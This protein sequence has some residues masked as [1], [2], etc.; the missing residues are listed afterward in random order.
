MCKP[1]MLV[2]LLA[3]KPL[4]VWATQ[5]ISEQEHDFSARFQVSACVQDVDLQRMVDEATCVALAQAGDMQ[6]Q[7]HLGDLLIQN[8]STFE[9]GMAWLKKAAHANFEPAQMRLGVVYYGDPSQSEQAIYWL[10]KAAAHQNLYA[11][12]FLA[13]IYKAGIG[14]PSSYAKAR[15]WYLQAANQHDDE[16][17]FYYLGL[18]AMTDTKHYNVDRAAYWFE[19]ASAKGHQASKKQLAL[20]YIAHARLGTFE[21]AELLLR[22]GNSG[23]QI[24]Q[25]LIDWIDSLSAMPSMKVGTKIASRWQGML[26]GKLK[27][28]RR[29]GAWMLGLESPNAWTPEQMDAWLLQAQDQDPAGQ[30]I[31]LGL[32]FLHG[33]GFGGQPRLASSYFFDA[34]AQH[35]TQAMY[36]LANIYLKGFG[37]Q[38]DPKLGLYWLKKAAQPY[39]EH[40]QYQLAQRLMHGLDTQAEPEAA[41][42][43]LT[44]LAEKRKSPYVLG[45]AMAYWF[46][47]GVAPDTAQAIQWFEEAAP[48]SYEARLVLHFLAQAGL[49]DAKWLTSKAAALDADSQLGLQLWYGIGQPRNVP[50]AMTAFERAYDAGDLVAGV[51]LMR[52][53]EF[54][55]G[56]PRNLAAV[57][58]L[59]QEMGFQRFSEAD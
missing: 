15:H 13:R 42:T 29:V 19:K 6:A 40:A 32:T 39:N 37:G 2:L 47:W 50:A 49:A 1:L 44:T 31:K 48:M 11:Q 52:N 58:H 5:S 43:L 10:K 41:L 54:G 30:R 33:L 18:L 21:Q 20:L 16:S 34:V 14:V 51:F 23:N 46:G 25:Q 12:L 8:P 26:A 56:T 22:E 59:Y 3:M 24:H 27:S 45:L 53:Y 55:F 38:R 57:R 17:A 28:E 4:A 7:W 36:W 35:S 9:E